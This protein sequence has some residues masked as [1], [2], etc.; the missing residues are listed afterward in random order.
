[1]SSSTDLDFPDD[2]GG[3]DPGLFG[4]EPDG[5]PPAFTSG[6]ARG[7][8][9]VEP[10]RFAGGTSDFARAGAEMGDGSGRDAGSSASGIGTGLRCVAGALLLEIGAAISNAS[11]FPH[12]THAVVPSALNVSQ[13]AQTIPISGSIE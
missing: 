7:S 4:T 2:F 5:R 13:R 3:I 8:G 6:S 11:A 1:M 12:E 10:W 9:R